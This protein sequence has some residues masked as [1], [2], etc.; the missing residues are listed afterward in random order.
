MKRQKVIS[1]KLPSYFF[2]IEFSYTIYLL[3]ILILF[4]VFIRLFKN[5]CTQK[6]LDSSDEAIQE[7]FGP[8]FEEHVRKL[9]NVSEDLVSLSFQPYE[10][11]NEYSACNVNGARFRT[12][13]RDRNLR[14]QNSGVMNIAGYGDGQE[15]EHY[16]VL[17]KVIELST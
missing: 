3:L 12:I 11:V 8:W 2:I 1:S 10:R 9:E 4:Y 17:K 13:D 14:T 15:T 7:E 16:G 6:G 5:E